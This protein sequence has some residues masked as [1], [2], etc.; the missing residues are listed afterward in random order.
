M[1]ASLTWIVF[2]SFVQLYYPA[3]QGFTA[4]GKGLAEDASSNTY[5]Y[6]EGPEMTSSP[7]S[8]LPPDGYCMDYC[9]QNSHRDLVGVEVYRTSGGVMKCKCLFSAVVPDSIDLTDYEP[10]AVNE[11]SPGNGGTGVIQSV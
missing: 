5:P 3:P 2:S 4:I 9:L 11:V 8:P 1:F 10:D 7:F 6:I